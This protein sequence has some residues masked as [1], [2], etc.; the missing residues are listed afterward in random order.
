M[1]KLENVGIDKCF[2]IKSVL[3]FITLK[4]DALIDME[5]N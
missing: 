4:I 3:C 2:A 1:L 5:N